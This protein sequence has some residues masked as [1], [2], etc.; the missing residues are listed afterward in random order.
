MV[1]VDTHTIGDTMQFVT[2]GNDASLCMW[3]IDFRTQVIEHFD[4][5]TPQSLK[6]KNF[7]SVCVT[8][9]LPEPVN[10]YYYLIGTDSGSLVAFNQ[11]TNEYVDLNQAN[12]Y[13][14]G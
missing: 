12:R 9:K 6:G 11:A 1:K 13:V 7:T 10:T 2:V 5:E 3:R 14:H 4:V 8:E